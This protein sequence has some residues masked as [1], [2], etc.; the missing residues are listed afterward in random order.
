MVQ[1]VK[2]SP[3]KQIRGMCRFLLGGRGRTRPKNTRYCGDPIMCSMI[4]WTFLGIMELLHGEDIHKYFKIRKSCEA[5]LVNFG[6]PNTSDKEQVQAGTHQSKIENAVPLRMSKNNAPWKINM[7]PKNRG[8]LKRKMIFHPPP[9]LGFKML[10]FQ[11]VQK[12]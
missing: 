12:S 6:W 5:S 7:E 1:S 3:Y 11:G 4:S 9:F 8:T 2:K 10:I